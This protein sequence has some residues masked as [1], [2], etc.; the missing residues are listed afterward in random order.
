MDGLLRPGEIDEETDVLEPR[1]QPGRAELAQAAGADSF[2]EDDPQGLESLS[3]KGLAVGDEEP[4][5]YARPGPVIAGEG[6][7]R[8]LGFGSGQD[9]EKVLL[10]D[11]VGQPVLAL[12]GEDDHAPGDNEEEEGRRH[13]EEV[14]EAIQDD[15]RQHGR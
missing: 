15:D 8:W 7:G 9:L 12:P 10:H 13:Q 3:D 14:G 1:R 5:E 6:H 2:L 4:L 11:V